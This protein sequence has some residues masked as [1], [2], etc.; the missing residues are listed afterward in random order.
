MTHWI[1]VFRFGTSAHKRQ[2][3]RVSK[4]IEQG[5]ANDW[6]DEHI[7]QAVFVAM[8]DAPIGSARPTSARRAKL[9]ARPGRIVGDRD[10]REDALED[11]IDKIIRWA[12]NRGMSEKRATAL[13]FAAVLLF[14]FGMRRER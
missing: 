12:L 13:A 8:L 9:P 7:A 1:Q 5:R 6:T 4:V 14:P 11:R 10:D 3:D 2:V